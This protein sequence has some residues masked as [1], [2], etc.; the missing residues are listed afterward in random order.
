MR[1]RLII[2]LS[3]AVVSAPVAGAGAA[4]PPVDPPNSIGIKLVDA[5]PYIVERAAP[6]TRIRRRVEITNTTDSTAAVAVYPAAASVLNGSFGFAP[7]HHGNKL[8]GWTSISRKL[9]RVPTRTSA[10]ETVTIA[11]PKNAA[12][13]ERYAVVWAEMSARS[14]AGGV[15]LVNRVGIRMYVSVGLG[16][17]PPANF[18][19]DPLSAERSATGAPLVVARVHNNGKRTLD[20]GGTLTLSDGPGGLRAGPVPVTLG[21]SLGPGEWGTA[22]I[23]L[24]K[25]LPVGPWRASLRLR[26]GFSQRSAVATLTFPRRLAVPPSGSR[27]LML[28][29]SGLLVVLLAVAAAVHRRPGGRKLTTQ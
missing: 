9:L 1:G 20:I 10:F 4:L 17:A 26:S 5:Q 2:A 19:I 6:G 22:T 28:G 24:D 14:P 16:G 11:I 29:I 27:H 18:T 12:F 13:G 21:T 8:S 23:R 3:L 7:A 25:R 15:T